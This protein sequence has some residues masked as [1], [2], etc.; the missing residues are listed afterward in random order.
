MQHLK[1]CVSFK[2]Y[3]TETNETI[4]DNAEYINAAIP[5]YNLTEYSDNYS[6]TSGTLWQFKRDEQ[7]INSNGAF[8]NLIAENCSLFKYK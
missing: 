8:I 4:A 7:P 3:R 6:D 2:E 1:N 5:I